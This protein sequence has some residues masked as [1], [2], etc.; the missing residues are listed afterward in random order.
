VS[1]VTRPAVRCCRAQSAISIVLPAPT[2]AATSVK[3]RVTACSSEAVSLPRSMH[4]SWTIG[5]A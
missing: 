4:W 5:I 1:H 2:G 3:A